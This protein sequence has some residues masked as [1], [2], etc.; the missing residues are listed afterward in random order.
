MFKSE[1]KHL[2]FLTMGTLSLC[3]IG[4]GIAVAQTKQLKAPAQPQTVEGDAQAQI[5]ST[6][7]T[8]GSSSSYSVV[9]EN[10]TNPDGKV[11]QS[12][13]VWQNGQ[14]VQEEEKTLDRTDAQNGFDATIQL[15]NGQVSPG[16]V[17]SSENEDDVF[18][19]VPSSPFEAI[20]QMEEQM[21][22][23]Q[24]RMRAQFD[25]L[26]QQ[27]SDPNGNAQGSPLQFNTP[28]FV[29]NQQAPSKFWIGATIERTPEFLTA[30]LPIEDEQG[31]W[32]QYI[33]PESP[34]AKAGLKKYDVLFRINGEIV[35][36]PVEVS[37]LVEQFGAKKVKIEYFRKGKLEKADLTIEERPQ[38]TQYGN[39]FGNQPNKNF[40][41]VR[42]GLI[43]PSTE[44]DSL[45]GSVEEKAENKQAQ[46][47]KSVEDSQETSQAE[48]IGDSEKNSSESKDSPSDK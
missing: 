24:E 18:G 46:E 27:L 38:N 15:P 47:A 26:R 28:S 42:P 48:E 17:F 1:R 30:Q 14:L 41:V 11:T 29:P 6:P 43:V 23:Q 10:K 5:V 4:G 31:V 33:A 34:A 16:G 45:I 20:R 8:N 35:S 19:S 3:L 40:R 39:V 9:I 22:A 2:S 7:L 12:R 44:A 36:N 21:R 37:K 25:A 13:K 32:I